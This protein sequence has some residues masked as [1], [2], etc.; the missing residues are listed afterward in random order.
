[1]K[2]EMKVDE[3]AQASLTLGDIVRQTQNNY[4]DPRFRPRT[5]E[6][7]PF[8]TIAGIDL[9][10]FEMYVTADGIGT[11]PELAERL[12]TESLI[13][14]NPTPHV[15][16][17][18]AF[19]TLA[20]ID[21]DEAR[22]GRYMVGV[23][24]IVDLNSAEDKA[25]VTALARGLKRAC[26]E[27][28][29]ALLNGETAEL[30]YRTSGF[31]QIRLNWNAVGISAFNPEKLIL[32]KDLKPGQPVVAFREKSIR[33][34]GLSKARL[35]LETAYLLSLGLL[36]KDKY[37]LKKLEEKGIIFDEE[38]AKKFLPALSEIF[39]HDALE[40]V[41]TPWHT[42]Y[43]NI[44]KQLLMPSKLY[45]PI[46][47]EAQGKI[48]E[49]RKIKM[50]AASHITGG[51]IPEKAKRMVENSGFGVS[52]D[53]VFPDPEGVTSLL[54]LANTFPD[55]IKA[56]VKINDRIA[57]EQWNR[58][59]GFIVAVENREDA[60]KLVGIAEQMDCEAAIAGEITDEP[61]INW[62]GNTWRYK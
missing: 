42:Q 5:H 59:V 39:G 24:E 32:G 50:I 30:G 7:T 51:G 3:K 1:M 10:P 40:Q 31:G 33:S 36:S 35:I 14:E 34:N 58:G 45:G 12:Y 47:R 46:I 11:K 43:P 27:G 9:K 21:G 53:A 62:R 8:Y 26:D 6:Q 41:L 37:V 25:V 54:E 17:G 56:K 16:E 52:L 57:S 44:V 29:F 48:D 55:D 18:L 15:F 60:K 2:Q 38:T 28:Q 13:A 19:D 4:P 61:E 22:F 20:M 49:P 23:A